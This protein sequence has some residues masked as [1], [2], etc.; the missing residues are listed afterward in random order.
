MV[1]IQSIKVFVVFQG[2]K[3]LLRKQTEQINV[4]LFL[5]V[6]SM[7]Y[8]VNLIPKLHWQIIYY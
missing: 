3:I 7:I 4:T 1:F 5:A 8:F 6:I 2:L